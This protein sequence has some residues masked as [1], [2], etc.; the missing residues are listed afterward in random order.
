MNVII[1]QY[2]QF[3]TKG[4][5][6]AAFVENITAQLCHQYPNNSFFVLSYDKKEH[7][8]NLPP[9]AQS[10]SFSVPHIIPPLALWQY[11][12][13]LKKLARQLQA[14]AIVHIDDYISIPVV[15]EWLLLRAPGNSRPDF[16]QSLSGIITLSLGIKNILAKNGIDA[17]RI[18]VMRCFAGALFKP[19]DWDTREQNKQHFAEGKEYFLFNAENAA[20]THLLNMLKGFSILKKWLKTGIKLIIINAALNSKLDAL[21]NTYKYKGDVSILEDTGSKA[22]TDLLASAFAFIYIPQSSK[23]GLP[24]LEAMQCAVPVITCSNDF[25]VELG[26]D[27]VMYIN[28]DSEQDIGEKL[29]K[30]YKDEKTRTLLVQKSE[31]QLQLLKENADKA[32]LGNG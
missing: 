18:K 31:A 27:A 28:P 6:G 30:I 10:I 1:S 20:H 14:D 24:L 15:K 3:L 29:I 16:L 22:Y 9:N 17:S 23:N 7:M 32:V 13:K 2:R 5:T 26:S 12:L 19:A 4:N 25:F 21:L 11:R 8:H